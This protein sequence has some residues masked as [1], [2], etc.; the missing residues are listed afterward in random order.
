MPQMHLKLFSRFTLLVLTIAMF[1]LLSHLSYA[2]VGDVE[3][4]SLASNGVEG[5][6]A[7]TLSA[8]SGNGRYITFSSA[9]NNLVSGDTNDHL[10]V[11]VHDTET[12]IVTRVSVA[13]NGTQGNH[14]SGLSTISAD[15]RYVA[16]LSRTTNLVTDDTNSFWDVF[17]HDRQTAETIRV[18][19]A[20]DGTPGNGDSQN[21]VISANG[22][23]VAFES[24]ASN[25]VAG[26]MNNAVDIFVH[27]LQTG[28]TSRVSLATNGA[29]GNSYSTS[30]DISADGRFITF[31]SDA[32]NLVNNDTNLQKDI[33]VRDRQN[34]TTI[35]V[36]VAASGAESDGDSANPAI[37]ANGQFVAFDS[38]ATNLVPRDGNDDIRDIFVRDLQNNTIRPVSLSITN[39]YGLG[40]SHMPALSADGRFV[41]F[42]TYAPSL[43][44]GDYNG[45]DE[46]VIIRDTLLGTTTAASIVGIGTANSH[47]FLPDISDDGRFVTFTSEATNLV[48]GDSNGVPDIFLYE[49]NIFDQTVYLPLVM[50][51]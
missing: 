20:S 30:P 3:R 17:V 2:A 44:H 50:N 37:S 27:D 1:L 9:A 22:R 33:F 12:D 43:V 46:D 34:N 8:I 16:F 26:D 4:I 14:D 29:E 47:S 41:V 10:D 35:R 5:N 28:E 13:T 23:F 49:N 7:S 15:G 36:S 6:E 18:S 51:N 38:Q 39:D 40:H 42:S 48:A 24:N 21:P 45:S 25:L 19:V 32:T 11:F 31:R